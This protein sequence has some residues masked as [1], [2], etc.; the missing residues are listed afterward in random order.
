M[1]YINKYIRSISEICVRYNAILKMLHKS[2]KQTGKGTRYIFTHMSLN[3]QSSFDGTIW[4]MSITLKSLNFI[5][6]QFFFVQ[7]FSIRSSGHLRLSDPIKSNTSK[8]SN[9]LCQKSVKW[10]QHVK[11]AMKV[12]MLRE[13]T[14]PCNL[15]CYYAL[16][17]R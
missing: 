8:Y 16:W 1:P 14:F 10:C 15:I 17:R 9:R 11:Q 12:Q 7:Q 3:L 4:I 2:G 13:A 6:I 5:F